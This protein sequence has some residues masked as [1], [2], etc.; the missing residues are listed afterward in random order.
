L[1]MLEC[2]TNTLPSCCRRESIAERLPPWRRRHDPRSA[3]GAWDDVGGPA[4]GAA[5]QCG[6][7]RTGWSS[8]RPPTHAL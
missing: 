2:E 7:R 8:D 5:Q 4:W 1:S 6:L 3:S